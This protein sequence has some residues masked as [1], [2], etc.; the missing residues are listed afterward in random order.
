MVFLFKLKSSSRLLLQSVDVF[1][2][3]AN[4]WAAHLETDTNK[5]R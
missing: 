5:R 1:T 2:I 4:Q 3:L